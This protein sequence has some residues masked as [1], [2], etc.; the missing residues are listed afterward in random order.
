VGFHRLAPP[1]CEGIETR[2]TTFQGLGAL[3]DGH[4]APAAC[5][6]RASLP[7]WPQFFDCTCHKEPARAPF[8]GPRCVHDQ[9]LE[10]IGTLHRD[11]S[12]KELSGVYQEIWENLILES[13]LY[14]TFA[15]IG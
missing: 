7:A 11:T 3:A 15:K 14:N 5:M 1:G 8:E 2:E 6:F 9:C 13:P 4:P 12:S 10:G